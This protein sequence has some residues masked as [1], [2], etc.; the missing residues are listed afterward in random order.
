M[1]DIEHQ[2]TVLERGLTANKIIE[3]K[4]DE[5][6]LDEMKV[7]KLLALFKTRF[8]DLRGT[9][10]VRAERHLYETTRNER[11]VHRR[12]QEAQARARS[13]AKEENMQRDLR[14]TRRMNLPSNAT[15]KSINY[16]PDT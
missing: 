12:N 7:S 9:A 13:I 8:A 3:N 6:V 11:D 10:I 16:P 15:H 14:T 5:A 4:I 2:V 1:S